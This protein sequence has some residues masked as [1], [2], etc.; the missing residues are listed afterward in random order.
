MCFTAHSDATLVPRF[1]SPVF[2][3]ELNDIFPA[4]KFKGQQLG[5]KGGGGA[6]EQGYSDAVVLE[7]SRRNMTT[8]NSLGHPELTGSECGTSLGIYIQKVTILII[9]RSN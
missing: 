4:N 1:S 3:F 8:F 7:I 9:L 2:T 5:Y 6:W